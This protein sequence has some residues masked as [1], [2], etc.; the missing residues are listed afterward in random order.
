[1]YRRRGGDRG[2]GN[3]GEAKEMGSLNGEVDRGITEEGVQDR[4]V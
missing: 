2:I 3:Q 1:M 4:K